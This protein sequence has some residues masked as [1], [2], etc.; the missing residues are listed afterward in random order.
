MRV[1]ALLAGALVLLLALRAA[2]DA[3]SELD[4]FTGTWLAESITHDGKEA[5]KDDVKKVFLNVKGANYTLF[6]GREVIKG[7]HT[8]D[9]GKKPKAIDAKRSQGPDKGKTI[10]G[11]YELDATTFKV[12]FAPADKDRPT[13]FE[14]KEGSGNRLLVF[15]RGK[16]KK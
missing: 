15:R 7:T 13:A 2:A 10:K 6:T 1:T 11:I 3:P 4:K 8:L 16:S 12:C 14:A 5:P 9:P